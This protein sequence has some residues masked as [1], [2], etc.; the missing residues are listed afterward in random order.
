MVDIPPTTIR[1]KNP[2]NVVCHLCKIIQTKPG[3]Q[4]FMNDPD[5]TEAIKTNDPKK[6]TEMTHTFTQNA[7]CQIQ[8]LIEFGTR[9]MISESFAV[10]SR[11]RMRNDFGHFMVC[12]DS[13]KFSVHD[14]IGL[15]EQMFL[16]LQLMLW[17]CISEEIYSSI[18]KILSQL[19]HNQLWNCLLCVTKCVSGTV[20]CVYNIHAT[21][22]E[23]EH[24]CEV[25]LLASSIRHIF[26]SFLLLMKEDQQVLSPKL[27]S[28]MNDNS[29]PPNTTGVLLRL[30]TKSYLAFLKK[31]TKT[32]PVIPRIG[33]EYRLDFFVEEL[34]QHSNVWTDLCSKLLKEKKSALSMLSSISRDKST[35]K[36]LHTNAIGLSAGTSQEFVDHDDTTEATPSTHKS[37]SIATKMLEAQVPCNPNH[38]QCFPLERMSDDKFQILRK[39]MMQTK[40]SMNNFGMFHQLE[41]EHD[42]IEAKKLS[43][44]ERCEEFCHEKFNKKYTDNYQRYLEKCAAY[45]GIIIHD[46]LG[47]KQS[48]DLSV[49]QNV[50]A[51]V[52][53]FCFKDSYLQNNSGKILLSHE[54]FFGKLLPRTAFSGTK[55]S[56][57]KL[58]SYFRDCFDAMELKPPDGDDH[59]LYYYEEKMLDEARAKKMMTKESED[60]GSALVCVENMN[61]GT[62]K[63]VTSFESVSCNFFF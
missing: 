53:E 20:R 2:A 45:I 31:M 32:E 47:V 8:S 40:N 48:N 9:G 58:L 7:L 42:S 36:N 35:T 12:A 30:V 34:G 59:L 52:L 10:W 14:K 23:M 54:I 24:P 56:A 28:T 25:L 1:K 46:I 16:A 5:V 44:L 38:L 39:K 49:N 41:R 19:K 22:Y 15:N 63:A 37:P 55:I 51:H 57:N 26:D 17:S 61:E 43:Y 4:F 18:V 13:S 6:L 3:C 33:K 62:N 50:F 21:P 11:K 29:T 60:A 27:S